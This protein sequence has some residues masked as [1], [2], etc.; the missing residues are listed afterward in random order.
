MNVKISTNGLLSFMMYFCLAMV[1]IQYK[2]NPQVFVFLLLFVCGIAMVTGKKIKYYLE[3]LVLIITF[4]AYFCISTQYKSIVYTYTYATDL[5]API[6]GYLCGYLLIGKSRKEDV[7]CKLY[8]VI[9]ILTVSMTCFALACVIY[10]NI[11][12]GIYNRQVSLANL[13]YTMRSRYGLNLWNNQLIQPTNLNSICI[14]PILLIPF[15][16]NYLNNKKWKIVFWL[17][18]GA[19]LVVAFETSTRTNFFMIP[20]CFAVG[21]FYN[22]KDRQ[23][24][25]TKRTLVK[26]LAVALVLVL[27]SNFIITWLQNS[28]ILSR[29]ETFD[30][31][32]IDSIARVMSLLIEYPYGN[33]PVTYAH[34]MWLDVARVAGIIPMI[35]LIIYTICVIRT[36][37]RLLKNPYIS[38]K[39]KSLIGTLTIGLLISFTVEPVIAGRPFNFM[40]FCLIN[41][42]CAALSRIYYN[43]PEEEL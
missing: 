10:K 39:A 43:V 19:S 41:G 21:Y 12:I 34:N 1:G 33:M 32:R 25:L 24:K 17:M 8:K 11:N 4:V 27:S 16:M 36:L 38:N 3:P 29:T 22:R 7:Y 20:I 42:M 14:F 2:N 26:F 6:T 40:F 9:A 13:Y 28:S 35:W 18:L 5:L 30:N 15:C 37:S 23:M 31:G